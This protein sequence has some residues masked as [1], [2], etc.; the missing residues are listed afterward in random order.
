MAPN[1]RQLMNILERL[2]EDFG[3]IPSSSNN[4]NLKLYSFDR[5]VYYDVEKLKRHIVNLMLLKIITQCAIIGLFAKL[6]F[7]SVMQVS[8]LLCK[9]N[10]SILLEIC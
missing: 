9:L 7:C 4:K 2:P 3:S 5:Q 1:S 6:W 10:Y 8:K